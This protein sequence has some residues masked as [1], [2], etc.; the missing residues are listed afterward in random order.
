MGEGI[1]RRAPQTV[2]QGRPTSMRYPNGRLVHFTYGSSGSDADLL[3]RLDAIQDDST[4]SPGTV[5]AAYDYLGLGQIV[6][7]DF[8][9]PDTKL[10]Y[11]GGTSGTYSGFDRFGR[12]TDQK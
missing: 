4:G 3:N 11:F 7:E 1:A 6:V 8:E 12:V 5:L 2:R 9:K 10:D